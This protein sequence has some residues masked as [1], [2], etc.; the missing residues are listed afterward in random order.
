MNP[1]DLDALMR[2]ALRCEP[3]AEQTARLEQFW[4]RQSRAA[5]RRDAIW[6][7]AAVAAT[8]MAAVAAG[9]LGVR[10]VHRDT[11]RPEVAVVPAPAIGGSSPPA[12]IATAGQLGGREPTPHEA[13][14]FALQ[15]QVAV[16]PE[17]AFARR[18]A[19]AASDEERREAIMELGRRGDEAALAVLLKTARREEL[20]NDALDAIEQIVGLER[21]AEVASLTAHADV[22]RALAARLL[23]AAS[24][25]AFRRYLALAGQPA[26]RGAALAAAESAERLP[27]GGLVAALDDNDQT[28]RLAA[29]VV[30]GSVHDPA[31][32]EALIARV[33]S[34]ARPPIEAWVALLAC[35]GENVSQFLVHAARQPRLLGQVNSAYA[36]RARMVPSSL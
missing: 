25:R 30:L 13:L 24:P 11:E 8:L 36:Y 1:D 34:T 32:S 21:L 3:A 6:R 12:K 5:R 16:S 29:A 22:R 2:R 9:L 15:T 26:T 17:R 14:M 7:G 19:R 27:I 4:R 23:T 20:R 33:T 18:F 28:L 35:R 10:L 31:V